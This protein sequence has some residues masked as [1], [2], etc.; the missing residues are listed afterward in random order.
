MILLP[1]SFG[2]SS[3]HVSAAVQ[4]SFPVFALVRSSAAPGHN[5]R[6]QDPEAQFG[7]GPVVE[8]G[9]QQEQRLYFAALDY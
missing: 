8:Q 1:P 4:S 6:K 2:P 7:A 3:T 5:L 9:F